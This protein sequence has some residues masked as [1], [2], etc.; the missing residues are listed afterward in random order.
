MW[1]KDVMSLPLLDE[2]RFLAVS[3]FV[4]AGFGHSAVGREVS[5]F[6][7]KLSPSKGEAE[8]WGDVD[9]DPSWGEVGPFTGVDS[10]KWEK[11]Y[12]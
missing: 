2:C 5:P 7:G 10:E 1:K 8:S 11:E 12:S 6:S 4:G 9:K 3:S